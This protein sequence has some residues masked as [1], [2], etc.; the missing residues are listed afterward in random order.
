MKY[1]KGKI[2]VKNYN[3]LYKI[4]W[5]ISIKSW[6]LSLVII[7]ILVL[8]FS[9]I[10]SLNIRSLKLMIL[11]LKPNFVNVL[12]KAWFIKTDLE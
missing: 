3:S 7:K 1:L 4:I 10:L 11:H 2:V 8:V 9:S 12:A 5:E 6:F